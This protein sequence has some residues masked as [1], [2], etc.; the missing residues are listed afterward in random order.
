M[1]KNLILNDRILSERLT[2]LE[3]LHR[4]TNEIQRDRS[5]LALGTHLSI[6]TSVLRQAE[7]RLRDLER[8]AER[9][10]AR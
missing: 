7:W 6:M 3:L 8:K 1:F 9:D 10:N 5:P 2:E 4:K